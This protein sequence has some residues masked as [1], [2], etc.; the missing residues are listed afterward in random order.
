MSL[1]LLLNN[2]QLGDNSGADF[3]NSWVLSASQERDLVSLM[4]NNCLNLVTS[5]TTSDTVTHPRE[6]M[7]SA[8]KQKIAN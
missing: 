7:L 1:T 6:D 2:L 3:E 8:L 4:Y 5:L